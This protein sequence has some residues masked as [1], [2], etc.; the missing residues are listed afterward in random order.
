MELFLKGVS[1]HLNWNT[2]YNYNT[3]V[4]TNFKEGGINYNKNKIAGV[5]PHTINS[6]LVLKSSYELHV[7]NFKYLQY[8]YQSATSLDVAN[9]I[10]AQSRELF[11]VKV[12]YSFTV[13]SWIRIGGSSFYLG[14]FSDWINEELYFD[15]HIGINNVFNQHY[16]SSYTT[17]NDWQSANPSELYYPGTPRHFYVGLKVNLHNN[18]FNK[19][20]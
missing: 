4:L 19:Q 9:S 5:V 18:T 15:F 1:N 16:A 14:S 17:A 12:G 11:H 7:R 3:S 10:Y 6:G 20:Y 8:E 2:S 13:P